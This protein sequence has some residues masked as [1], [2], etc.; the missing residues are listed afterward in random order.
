MHPCV[1][2]CAC[3]RVCVCA[4]AS[5]CVFHT[6]S[7]VQM[8]LS[9][10]FRVPSID[11]T[12]STY[13]PLTCTFFTANSV[14]WEEGGKKGRGGE[15]ERGREGERERGGEREGRGGGGRGGNLLCTWFVYKMTDKGY[16]YIWEKVMLIYIIG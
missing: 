9:P 3:I 7:M 15:G 10:T 2:V 16:K 11:P 13:P 1:C 6:P 4:R 8:T 5:V 14:A 12:C